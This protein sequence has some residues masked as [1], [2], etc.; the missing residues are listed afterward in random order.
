MIG[1]GKR[2]TP[3]CFYYYHY[4]L[5]SFITEK[6]NEI[7]KFSYWTKPQ[8][9]A[10]TTYNLDRIVVAKAPEHKYSSGHAQ[11]HQP[12]NKGFSGLRRGDGG[13]M[14]DQ[15]SAVHLFIFNRR[16][17]W[18]FI[19]CVHSTFPLVVNARD[20]RRYWIVWV[21]DMSGRSP[22]S[23]KLISNHANYGK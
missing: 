20:V 17:D 1:T 15:W 23:R 16:R 19:R 14:I 21:A 3:L 6:H 8:D 7:S 18:F 5:P 12:K 4:S 2:G 10:T 9:K 13:D 22:M 11:G